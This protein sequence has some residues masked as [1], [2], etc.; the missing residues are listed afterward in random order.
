MKK[1][2]IRKIP[3]NKFVKY[4]KVAKE[5][6]EMAKEKKVEEPKEEKKDEKGNPNVIVDH[7][8]IK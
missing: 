5:A 8:L 3:K 2:I 1:K 6:I 4:K 7:A